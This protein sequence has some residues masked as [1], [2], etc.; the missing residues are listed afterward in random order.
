V[1]NPMNENV[2]VRD[3]DEEEREM[4]RGENS[5]NELK[6]YLVERTIGF[7]TSRSLGALSKTKC[8]T[9]ICD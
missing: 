3:V 5:M 7:T 4:F 6:G 1:A 2:A 8:K 9:F